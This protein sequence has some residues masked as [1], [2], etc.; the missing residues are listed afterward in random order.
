[1]RE[2]WTAELIFALRPATSEAE[3]A[4]NLEHFAVPRYDPAQMSASA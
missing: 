2:K 3:F 4:K 1:V